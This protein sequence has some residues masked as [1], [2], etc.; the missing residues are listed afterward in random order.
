MVEETPGG[1]DFVLT[2]VV[3]AGKLILNANYTNNW[4]VKKDKRVLYIFLCTCSM[5]PDMDYIKS[6]AGR[7]VVGSLYT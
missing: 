2:W 5:R 3:V 6:A 4:V 1:R 7:K